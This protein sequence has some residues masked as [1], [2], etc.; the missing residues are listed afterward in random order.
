MLALFAW[1][2]AQAELPAIRPIERVLPPKGIE[3]PESE[4][5]R[6]TDAVRALRAQ[7]P[8]NEADRAKDHWADAEVFVKAVEFALENGEFYKPDDVRKA[9]RLLDVAAERIKALREGRAPW[10]KQT[11]LV[12]RGFI[13]AIDGTAQPYGVE[14]PENWAGWLGRI[15]V[16]VH[17]CYV[18]LHG[19]GDT[20]TD[21]HF[22]HE[23]MTKPGQFQNENGIVIH[24]FGRHCLGYKSAGEIDVLE[25]RAAALEDVSDRSG[26]GRADGIFDGWS[27]R[28]ASRRALPAPTGLLFTPEPGFVDTRRYQNIDPAT[29][30]PWEVKLWGL[31]DV[32]ALAAIFWMFRSSFTAA[33]STNRRPP[34]TSWKRSCARK[35][36]SSVA[37]SARAWATSTRP[38]PSSK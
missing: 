26:E 19:R 33:N 13:S 10:K 17:S 5:V 18:W 37:S 15:H 3:L 22:I 23:R 9:D 20:T 34:L 32:P 16:R 24:P 29:R 12:V 6:L 8:L 7:I 27:R 11:G 4:R 31:Y 14:V 2:P 1:S 36:S 21:M 30:P 28:V 35:G 25:A 38:R